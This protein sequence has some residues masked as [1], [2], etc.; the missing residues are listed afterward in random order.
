[1][2]HEAAASGGALV[3]GRM[4]DTI[5]KLVA[6][7]KALDTEVVSAEDELF[8]AGEQS[9]A[10]EKEIAKVVAEATEA[11]SKSLEALS[12]GTAVRLPPTQPPCFAWT[13]RRRAVA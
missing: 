5:E 7:L 2:L 1:M 13:C 9:A 12:E 4:L 11:E 6:Q 10:L 8:I 3:F